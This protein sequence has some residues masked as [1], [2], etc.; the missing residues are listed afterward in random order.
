MPC[1]SHGHSTIQI[2]IYWY[3]T[4]QPWWAWLQTHQQLLGKAD[5]PG[6]DC[7]W[8]IQQWPITSNETRRNQLTIT[9][10][11]GDVQQL[12]QAL[13]LLKR[14]R[15]LNISAF[16]RAAIAEKLE[17]LEAVKWRPLPFACLMQRRRC[18][19]RCR[20]WI[21][22]V[23]TSKVSFSAKS[24]RNTP[25]PLPPE[26]RGRGSLSHCQRLT[27]RCAICL[28]WRGSRDELRH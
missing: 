16:C 7:P 3:S 15:C 28:S 12:H 19:W 25:R 1:C 26:P 18:W 17:R 9:Y 13:L 23:E 14:S 2:E 8:P 27:H 10:P 24:S 20:R 6:A 22:P 11:E 21:E 4:H 5:Q